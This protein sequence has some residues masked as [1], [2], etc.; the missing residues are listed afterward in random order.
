VQELVAQF[1]PV[2]DDSGLLWSGSDTDPERA[3]FKKIKNQGHY[4][5]DP[6]P[7]AHGAGNDQGYYALTPSGILLAS[8]PATDAEGVAKM[9][10]EALAK[11]QKLPKQQR[12]PAEAPAKNPANRHRAEQNYPVDG[13][14]LSVNLRDLP[15]AHMTKDAK[16]YQWT[17]NQD[18]AWFTK[19]QASG[20]VPTT[21]TKGATHQVPDAIIRRLARA[22]FIDNVR[23]IT[24]AFSD[25]EVEKAGLT[26]TVLS[27]D[28]DIATLRYEGVTR[29]SASGTWAV[30][31][32]PASKQTRGFDARLLGKA[33]YNIKAGKFTSFALVALGMR[34][35]GTVY[36][37]RTEDLDPAPMGITLTLAGDSPAE[38]VAPFAAAWGQ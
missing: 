20:W 19:D 23:S 31:Q 28:G 6:H 22:T 38:R 33:T 10:K 34:W 32:D 16:T 9:L 2:G 21:W 36:N 15:R 29:T 17:W 27:V 8:S 3:L 18:Y 5:A 4:G 37:G 12:L 24:P 1:I 7:D 30:G 14:V 25:A 11:W 35:G 13:L 26:A